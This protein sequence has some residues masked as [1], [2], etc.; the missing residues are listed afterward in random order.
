[1]QKL[2]VSDKSTFMPRKGLIRSTCRVRKRRCIPSADSESCQS[3]VSHSVSCSLVIT[4]P[5]RHYAAAEAILPRGHSC[6]VPVSLPLTRWPANISPAYPALVKQVPDVA[7]TQLAHQN[8]PLKRS[9]SSLPPRAVL[10]ELIEL[11]FLLIHN[12]SHTLFHVPS[13]LREL[14]NDEAPEVLLLMMI[15]LSARYGITF[16]VVF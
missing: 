4:R 13:F 1:M 16:F 15:A 5:Y 11:Y 3:C 14:E 10:K 2:Q 6:E 8:R 12:G 9:H 7:T